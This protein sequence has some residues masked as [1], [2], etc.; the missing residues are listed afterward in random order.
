MPTINK[1]SAGNWQVK[2]RKKGQPQQSKTFRT[3]AA[4]ERWS[5][6]TES[7]MERGVFVS[8]AEAEQTTLDELLDRYEEEVVPLKKSSRR[9]VSVLNMLRKHLGSLS[10]AAITPSVAA[11]YRDKRLK[12]VSTGTVRKDL[13]LLSRVLSHAQKEWEL[14]LPRGNPCGS[15]RMPPNG[16]ARDRRLEDDEEEQLLKHARLYGG[17]IESVVVFAL[18]TAARRGEIANLTWNNVDLKK[19]V[20]QF[21]DTKNGENRRIPLSQRCVALLESLPRNIKGNVFRMRPDSITQAFEAVCKLSGIEG[22]RFHDLRHEATSRLFEKGLSIMEVSSVTGHK[23][24]GM[25]K[26][27]T[28]LKPEDL[29]AKLG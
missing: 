7:E 6:F 20:A 22:L 9:I 13:S 4:A 16:K 2:V 15:I 29:V 19:Y 24:L 28:H 12:N 1:R 27:Y 14:Y 5:K 17:E 18:E 10:V 21:V 25:L 23:D 26:R 11:S 8:S 3:K